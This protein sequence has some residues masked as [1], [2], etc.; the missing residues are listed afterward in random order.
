MVDILFSGESLAL[1]S[2][3]FWAIA[4]VLFK[5]CGAFVPPLTLNLFK[6]VVALVVFVPAVVLVEGSLAPDRPA[7]EWLLLGAS[8]LLGIT[9]SDTLFFAAL[10]RLGAG[11]NAIVDCLYAPSMILCASLLLDERIPGLALVGT[12]LILS[13][14]L[15]GAIRAEAGPKSRR[16]LV[17]GVF[18]GAAGMVAISLSIA[19]VKP[20]LV[21]ER[22]LWATTL[23]LAW[24]T[25]ALLPLILL[26][27]E[28]RFLPVAFRP[29]RLFR[30]TI[31]A[32][33]FGSALA[34]A[35]WI[36]GLT[37]LPVSFSAVLNQLATI[38]IFLLAYPVLG[39][40]LTKRR[41]AAVALAFGGAALAWTARG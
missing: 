34:M 32:S 23:R 26:R 33:I 21:E 30:L 15:L 13:A 12:L 36:A 40:P 17:V 18:Y 27:E 31:P 38:F 41:V 37:L 10:N 3:V 6:C 35:S 39:E 20:F 1:A 16:D 29:S 11:L 25:L 5:R 8:G 4:V 7:R 19:I 24:G 9:V 14:I 2:A 22:I 28:R